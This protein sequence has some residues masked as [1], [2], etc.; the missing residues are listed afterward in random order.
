MAYLIDLKTFVDN[1]GVL[2]VIDHILPF[3]ISRV[4]Y[5][6]GVNEAEHRGGHR[7]FICKEAVVSIQGS[8]TAHVINTKGSFTYL[9]ENADNC[10][11]IEPGDWHEFY[12]FTP[13]T[14]LLGLSSTAYDKDDYSKE[15]LPLEL[16]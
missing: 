15:P 9:I 10:L 3:N 5:I 14:V 13:N 16:K 1:R 4:Y 7:H 2:T 8:F 6:Q 12:N 11:I